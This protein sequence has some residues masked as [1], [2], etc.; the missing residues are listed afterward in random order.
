MLKKRLHLHQGIW[1]CGSLT[2]AAP[3]TSKK[4]SGSSGSGWYRIVS[5]PARPSPIE[6]AGFER[7]Q[8]VQRAYAGRS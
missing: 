7:T 5:E 8:G 2:L 3:R 4:L 6:T 1:D